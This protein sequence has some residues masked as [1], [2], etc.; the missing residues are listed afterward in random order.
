MIIKILLLLFLFIPMLLI[1]IYTYYE[2]IN[3]QY[4]KSDFLDLDRVDEL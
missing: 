1:I 3:I 4:Y 2:V